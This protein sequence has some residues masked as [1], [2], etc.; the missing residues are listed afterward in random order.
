MPK[1]EVENSLVQ[2]VQSPVEKWKISLLS[3]EKP[4]GKPGGKCG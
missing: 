2:N 3:G 1:K 4:G